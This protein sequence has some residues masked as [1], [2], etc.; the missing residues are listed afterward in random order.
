MEARECGWQSFVLACQ[1]T[2]A[3]RPGKTAL[4]DPAAWQQHEALLGLGRTCTYEPVQAV[5]YLSEA[6]QALGCLFGHECQVRGD[7]S[8]FVIAYIAG[9]GFTF[10]PPS[11][12]LAT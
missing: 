3:R 4:A 2:K 1:A 9:V 6:V 10:H 12:S 8:P 5:E 11:L 7:K